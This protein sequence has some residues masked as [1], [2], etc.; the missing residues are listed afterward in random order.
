MALG[1]AFY[2]DQGGGG[3]TPQFENLGTVKNS[4]ITLAYDY[5]MVILTGEES[6]IQ[7]P[8][9]IRNGVE[10]AITDPYY[11]SDAYKILVWHVFDCK[12]G[13][14]IKGYPNNNYIYG[15]YGYRKV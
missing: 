13:D 5:D 1:K 6:A 3:G 12:A 7:N 4:T 2:G 14:I 15:V 11:H 9:I 10:Q 8:S